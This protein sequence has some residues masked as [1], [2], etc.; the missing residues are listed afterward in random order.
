MGEG[1]THADSL[2]VSF[3]RGTSGFALI[4]LAAILAF[5]ARRSIS[6]RRSSGLFMYWGKSSLCCRLRAGRL[7]AG[8]ELVVG[9]SINEPPRVGKK[10]ASISYGTSCTTTIGSSYYR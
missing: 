4:S 9:N 5:S 8:L 6:L 10:R 7:V 3:T 2:A 1:Q